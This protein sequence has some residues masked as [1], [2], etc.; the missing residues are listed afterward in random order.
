[1]AN[2]LKK[3]TALSRKSSRKKFEIQLE[4]PSTLWMILGETT[5][6]YQALLN[7]CV[8]ARDAMPNGGRLT[9]KLENVEITA[10][11]KSFHINAKEGEYVR[12]TVSDT[13]TGIPPEVL[14]KIFEPFFTTKEVG[15][16]TGLGLSVVYSV[17]NSHG[18]FCGC[19]N[20][21]RQRHVFHA[22]FSSHEIRAK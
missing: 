7:L 20:R 22:L 5:K 19:R 9:I 1:L 10:A 12:L 15:R 21:S 3:P 2:W 13:G 16:G 18:G 17:M 4:V 14:D 8:N 6:I 11:Q